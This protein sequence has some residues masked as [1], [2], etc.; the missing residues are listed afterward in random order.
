MKNDLSAY[1]K[2]VIAEINPQSISCCQWH[3]DAVAASLRSDIKAV[4]MDKNRFR[5]S[6]DLAW[7]AHR[8]LR[9]VNTVMPTGIFRRVLDPFA[10]DFQHAERLQATRRMR[11]FFLLAIAVVGFGGLGD[12]FLAAEPLLAL[13]SIKCLTAMVVVAL[14]ILTYNASFWRWQSWA[15]LAA[16]MAL[17][18]CWLPCT[19]RNQSAFNSVYVL[20]YAVMLLG[21]LAMT[22]RLS[23]QLLV[24]TCT[25]LLANAY[26]AKFEA[27]ALTHLWLANAVVV[28]VGAALIVL[29]GFCQRWRQ[30]YFTQLKTSTMRSAAAKI[31]QPR[32]VTIDPFTGVANRL[33]LDRL[34]K[35]E[36]QQIR[37]QRGMISLLLL[38]VQQHSDLVGMAARLRALTQSSATCIARF[39]DNSLAVLWL[40]PQAQPTQRGLHQL[41]ERLMCIQ[42]AI[43]RQPTRMSVICLQP[44]QLHLVADLYRRAVQALQPL[45]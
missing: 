6:S 12:L 24:L 26:W 10:K 27:L 9:G 40:D 17:S 45:V 2:N 33:S 35:Q 15:M 4:S 44:S 13:A 23:S 42:P 16:L 5:S 31:G 22:W 3:V 7:L 19:V 11:L 32:L 36:W 1:T 20:V 41:Q 28:T 43:E 14:S 21:L 37:Q 29:G 30:A 8:T 25:L 34:L 18:L 39:N 38:Q